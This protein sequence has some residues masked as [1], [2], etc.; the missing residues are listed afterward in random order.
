MGYLRLLETFEVFVLGVKNLG[1]VAL[2]LLLL[3]LDVLDGEGDD[4]SAY[5]D[6]HGVMSLESQLVLE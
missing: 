1:D 5:L 6:S 2:Q 3:G 4:C